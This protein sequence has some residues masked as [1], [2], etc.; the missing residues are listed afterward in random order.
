MAA[1]DVLGVND[2]ADCASSGREV[3]KTATASDPGHSDYQLRRP[4]GMANRLASRRLGGRSPPRI[5]QVAAPALSFFDRAEA[6]LLA[7]SCARTS[8]LIGKPQGSLEFRR[9][10]AVGLL[11]PHH[12]P[13]ERALRPAI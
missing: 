4:S 9:A 13:G 1:V 8:A 11:E 3:D 2:D 5:C 12:S 7:A 10:G 6:M